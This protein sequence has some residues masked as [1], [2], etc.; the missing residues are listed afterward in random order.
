[1][2][3]RPLSS[4]CYIENRKRFVS[5]LKPGGLAVFNSNDIYPISAD[6]TLPFAQHRDIFYLSGI[7]QEESILLLFPD[8]QHPEYREV[9]FLKKTNSQIAV[10]EGKKLTPSAATALSGI[11][12]VRWLED[13]ENVFDTLAQ[14]AKILYI[15]T[16]EHLRAK[17]ETQTREDR[18]IKWAKA[19]FP[20]LPTAKSNFIL[21]T[22]RS[23]KDAEEMEQIQKAIGIT[24][25]G[26]RRVLP[27]IQPGICE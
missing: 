5:E 24:E 22:L 7:D 2:R 17:V 15:N 27:L 21:H 19:K 10:W 16:N 20:T 6:S 18:F 14:E 9:L 11:G 13:F 12:S 4:Q 26:V 1:M 23:I 3:Y 25:K 8:A